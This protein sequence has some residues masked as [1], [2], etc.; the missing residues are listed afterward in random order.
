MKST[1][2]FLV[3]IVAVMVVGCQENG[4]LDPVSPSSVV[5]TVSGGGPVTQKSGS[6]EYSAEIPDAGIGGSEGCGTPISIKGVAKYVLTATPGSA[7]YEVS[8]TARLSLPNGKTIGKVKGTVLSQQRLENGTAYIRPSYTIL[9]RPDLKLVLVCVIADG[10]IN[11]KT[12]YLE[13]DVHWAAEG[14]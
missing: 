5:P 7:K 12:L 4:S 6:F 10:E 3:A 11:F 9:G 14:D 13:R 2:L 1:A 8:T